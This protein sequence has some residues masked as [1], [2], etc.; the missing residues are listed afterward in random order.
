[1]LINKG[2]D[3]NADW[4]NSIA[5]SRNNGLWK[6][7]SA[8]NITV[9]PQR[10]TGRNQEQK[11]KIYLLDGIE[12]LENLSVIYLEDAVD[13]DISWEPLRKLKSLKQLYCS[14]ALLLSLKE[15]EACF[16]DLKGYVDLDS[17]K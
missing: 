12:E 16:N 17:Q 11:F 2:T 14:S 9:S 13:E 7:I 3:I 8:L 4:T 10:T 6:T 5:V 15:D 1:M